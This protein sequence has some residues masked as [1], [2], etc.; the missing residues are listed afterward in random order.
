MVASTSSVFYT[1]TKTV[2]KNLQMVF[3]QCVP[4]AS[5]LKLAGKTG[6]R[7]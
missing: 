2:Q 3:K 4:A 6:A 7:K 5:I 1:E